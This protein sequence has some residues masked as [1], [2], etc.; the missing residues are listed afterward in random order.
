MTLL[1]QPQ[2]MVWNQ[3]GLGGGGVTPESSASMAHPLAAHC[4]KEPALGTPGLA[5]TRHQS[6]AGRSPRGAFPP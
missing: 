1:W 3:T 5:H 4:G 6:V 2:P